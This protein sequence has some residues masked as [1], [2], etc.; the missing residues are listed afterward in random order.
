[1]NL[2]DLRWISLAPRILGWVSSRSEIFS[3]IRQSVCNKLQ[4]AVYSTMNWLP[5]AETAAQSGVLTTLAVLAGN[6]VHVMFWLDNHVPGCEICWCDRIS[7][8]YCMSPKHSYVAVSGCE[9][10]WS[11]KIFL[12]IRN[13]WIFISYQPKYLRQYLPSLNELFCLLSMLVCMCDPR[14]GSSY[15]DFVRIVSR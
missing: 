1:M 14:P 9:I 10:C 6:L 4:C 3:R 2:D 5:P 11:V 7:F 8:I 12:S 13:L 15:K